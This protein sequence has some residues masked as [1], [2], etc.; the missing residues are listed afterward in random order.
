[1]AELDPGATRLT[2]LRVVLIEDEP[3]LALCLSEVIEEHGGVVVGAEDSVAAALQLVSTAQFDIAVLDLNLHGERVDGIARA[4]SAG[5]HAI[6]FSTGSG[7]SDIPAEF[8]GWP[9][10]T[11][12]YSDDA[13]LDAFALARGYNANRAQTLPTSADLRP[14]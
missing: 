9:V 2:G 3:I 10:L 5:G 11:K 12:P 14:I 7:P 4:L 13:L 8:Q 6:I 1:M